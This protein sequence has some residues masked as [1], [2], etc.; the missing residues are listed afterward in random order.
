MR[1]HFPAAIVPAAGRHAALVT[2]AV[3]AWLVVT[4]APASAATGPRTVATRPAAFATTNGDVLAVKTTVSNGRRVLVFGGNFSAVITPDGRTYA[5]SHVAAVDAGTGALVW[6]GDA[7]GYVRTIA[8]LGGRVYLGG[9]FT[10][11][12]GVPRSRLAALD[13]STWAVTAWNPGATSRVRA[14][15]ASD[16]LV[17]VA[18]GNAVRALTPAGA[19]RWRDVADCSVNAL[20]VGPTATRL[21][22]G[23][24]FNRVNGVGQHSLVLV[25]AATGQ[26]DPAFAPVLQANSGACGAAGRAAYDGEDTISMTY[27]TV[28]G[29]LLAGQGGLQNS[30]RSL[31]P[32][33]GATAWKRHTPGD[34]QALSMVGGMVFVGYH[35]NNPNPDGSYTNYFAALRTARTGTLVAWDP[36]LVGNQA[37]ADGG[38][39]GV[40]ASWFDPALNRL[41][42]GGSF[43]PP[44]SLA[45]F[46]VT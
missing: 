46:A 41:Y 26:V 9:D 28:N 20:L 15:A 34:A 29:R 38:N 3:V 22:V 33:T 27:D 37:N 35:R 1:R 40:Q 5:A 6:A 16:T 18:D 42:L 7:D 4:G 23:G 25:D 45:A 32:T 43:F 2:A 21:Y 12:G 8:L 24:F 14:L 10:R 13:T 39:N 11:I 44:Q 31:D 17:Y 30:L 19:L 36:G